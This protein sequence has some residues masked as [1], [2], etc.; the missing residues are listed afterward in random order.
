[1]LFTLSLSLNYVLSPFYNSYRFLY[2]L[3]IKV[4]SLNLVFLLNVIDKNHMPIL[5]VYKHK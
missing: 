5:F 1:M 4:F 3:V 2:Q